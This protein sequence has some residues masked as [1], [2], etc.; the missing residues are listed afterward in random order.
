MKNLNSLKIKSKLI[1]IILLITTLALAIAFVSFIFYGRSIFQKSLE[2][3]IDGVT[4]LTAN[5]IAVALGFL[6]DDYWSDLE[7]LVKMPAIKSC[8]VYN[9][10]GKLLD[11][12]HQVPSEKS[13]PPRFVLEKEHRM[14]IAGEYIYVYAPYLQGGLFRNLIR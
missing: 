4:K 1:A 2:E 8:Y 14:E 5:N 10:Q 9:N 13:K 3:E 12:R 6:S 7:S 11:E